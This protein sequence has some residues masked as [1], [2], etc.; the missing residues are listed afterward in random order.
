LAAKNC[1][2]EIYAIL[3]EAGADEDAKNEENR[4]PKQL[5]AEHPADQPGRPEEE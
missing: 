2:R 1:D 3:V 4:T 5:L